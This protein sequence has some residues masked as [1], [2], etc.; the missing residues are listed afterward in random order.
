MTVLMMR[1]SYK[2]V[3]KS[4]DIAFPIVFDNKVY[5]EVVIKQVLL[6]LENFSVSSGPDF[7]FNSVS[8]GQ[9]DWKCTCQNNF[10]FPNKFSPYP[11]LSF[12]TE[13]DIFHLH[14]YKHVFSI[15]IDK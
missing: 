1:D 11:K 6:P 13:S 2:Y 5:E 3:K 4:G 12:I 10:H 7:F 14:T 8:P 15:K 9:V